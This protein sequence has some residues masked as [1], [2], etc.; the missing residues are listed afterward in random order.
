MR[1]T[2][3]DAEAFLWRAKSGFGLALAW[4]LAVSCAPA[5]A[6]AEGT[7]APISET[8]AS[9]AGEGVGTPNPA[10]PEEPTFETVL[11]PNEEPTVTSETQP[12]EAPTAEAAL[13][14]VREPTDVLAPE[15]TPEPAAVSPTS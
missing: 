4:C 9:P 13:K 7:D 15:T 14:P 5:V 3:K 8:A 10:V 2:Q 12:T 1:T 11:I 6:F